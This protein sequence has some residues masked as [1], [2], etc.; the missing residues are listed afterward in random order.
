MNGKIKRI[1]SVVVSLALMLTA[2]PV[3]GAS[4]R[5]EADNSTEAVYTCSSEDGDSERRT[6]D[7]GIRTEDTETPVISSAEDYYK[8]TDN[9]CIGKNAVAP[10]GSSELPASVD[11]SESPYFPPIGDQGA[12][13]ACVVFATTYYQFTYTM[14][15]A[16]G[17]E[18][19]EDNIFSVKWIYNIV[20][21]GMDNGSNEF[22]I[23]KVLKQHGCPTA[24]S[25]PYDGVDFKGWSTDEKVWREAIRYRLSDSQ[26][27]ADLGGAGCEIT[28]ADD[29][30]LIAVKTALNNGDVLKF[31]SFIYSWEYGN[32]K[33]NADVPENDKYKNEQYVRV[34]SG[35][36]GGHGMAIVGYNDNIWCD[37]NNND[38][39]DAG[40]MGAFKIANSWS[41][42]YG[43]KGFMW[44]AYDALNQ[45][46]CLEGVEYY[47]DRQPAISDV[48]RIDV[49]DVNEGN[50]RYL[51]FTLNTQDR[52][53]F[54]V[55]FSADKNGT[56]YK[57][58]F[59]SGIG[60]F[61]SY[62]RYAFDGTNTACDATFVYP[63]NDLDPNISAENFEQYNFG[64]TIK[65]RENDGI[66][67]VIKSVSLVDEH[68]GEEYKFNGDYPLTV[69]GAEYSAVVKESTK[70]NAVV[71]YIG[72]DNPTIHFKNGT[73]E[74]T[75]AK[76]EEN[77]ER[78]GALYKYIIYDIDGEVPVYFTDDNGNTDSNG[79]VN[80]TAQE[81]LNFFYTK[82]QREPLTIHDFDFSNGTADVSKRCLL[83]PV[84][85]GGYETYRYRYV[86]E[87]LATGEVKEYD[88][89]Y[90]YEMSPFIFSNEGTYR[91]TV[92]VMDYAKEVSKLTKEFEVVNHPFR[93]ES[94]TCDRETLLVSKPVQFKSI[95]AFEGIASWGGYKAQSQFVIKDSNGKVWHDKVVTYSTYDMKIKTTTTLYEFI[96]AKAGEYTLTVSS[97]D[98]NK[99]YAEKTISF[100]VYDMLVGDAN[101]D[102]KVNI[103]DATTIQ[104]YLADLITEEDFYR[105]M[106]DCDGNMNVNIK[107]AT[108]IQCYI[109]NIEKDADTG[110]VIEYIPPTEA[111]TEAPTEPPTQAPTEAPTE[112]PTIPV[113]NNKVTF[114]NSHNWSGTI[115]CYYWSSENTA[116]TSWPGTAMTNAGVNDFA[117]T[118]YTFEVPKEATFIIFTNGSEQTVDIAYS[119]GEVRCYP[120][121]TKTGNGYNVEM[122]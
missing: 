47:E 89:D 86:I 11:N 122:W 8:Y 68:T 113:V 120:L 62:N 14:N 35:Y 9:S 84:V 7:L 51:K 33:T 46:S 6:G 52:S 104:R 37:V 15:K 1:C 72:F 63:L 40:E 117:Q 25:L 76:M 57:S 69:D 73:Y 64:I 3:F 19:N 98:C 108:A 74:F 97:Y 96:P 112:P 83:A 111:P 82:G 20:N 100:T 41:E 114:T 91:I 60:Y 10:I 23:Y 24:K 103:R 32:L 102:G 31:S 59:L 29:T 101:G 49:C 95:T 5:E 58:S 61:S 116:M 27:F 106:S 78:L 87:N 118:L 75:S 70:T 50:D 119:G 94:L 36:E 107:D 79:G 16:R 13:G 88:F 56:Q 67:L 92:E 18:S 38:V 42:G 71:Y 43:N 110:K 65:D 2:V 90:N 66:P 45:V 44:I 55:G 109:A 80:Y 121:T 48:Y 53:Q 54:S 93:I 34:V 115:Y 26:Q 21:A 30:D 17:V 28:S 77:S 4:A 39:V 12:L 85:T 81:G 99:E 22:V 105:E